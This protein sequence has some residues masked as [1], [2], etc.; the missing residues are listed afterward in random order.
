MNRIMSRLGI[1]A[2]AAVCSVPLLAGVAPAA[3]NDGVCEASN[4]EFCVF[5]QADFDWAADF[6]A[7]D[8]HY[9]NNYYPLHPSYSVDNSVSSIANFYPCRVVVYENPAQGGDTLVIGTGY[10]YSN[11]TNVTGDQYG[12]NMNNEIGG[13]SIAC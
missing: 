9:E 10:G 1:L 4:S 5:R 7:S 2:A 6:K 8:T 13:H 3:S 11:L 12:V